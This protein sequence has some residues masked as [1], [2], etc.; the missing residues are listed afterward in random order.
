MSEYTKE[1]LE[2]LRERMRLAR[3]HM[4][5]AKLEIERALTKLGPTITAWF[6]STEDACSCGVTPT[7]GVLEI[8]GWIAS[9]AKRCGSLYTN[10]EERIKEPLIQKSKRGSRRGQY[11]D[12]SN[13]S[14]AVISSP[15]LPK[16]TPAP[17]GES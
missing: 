10:V 6:F 7:V 17:R 3:D 1:E 9:M 4:D 8:Y 13:N 11:L 15:E 2:A 12:R 5:R 16:I 14:L